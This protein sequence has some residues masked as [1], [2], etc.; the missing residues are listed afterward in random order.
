M[1]FA[2]SGSELL[3]LLLIVHKQFTTTTTF[4]E[5]FGRRVNS[6]QFFFFFFFLIFISFEFGFGE[7]IHQ[8]GKEKTYEEQA[9][10]VVLQEVTDSIIQFLS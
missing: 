3:P 7:V 4:R 6:F 5:L 9:L 2:C 10:G 8:S 1:Q